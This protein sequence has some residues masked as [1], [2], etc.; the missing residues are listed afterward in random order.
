[1]T[2]LV[3]QLSSWIDCN[4][5]KKQNILRFGLTQHRTAYPS[6]KPLE[7]AW[8][9]NISQD[10]RSRVI[11]QAFRPGRPEGKI[12]PWQPNLM[13]NFAHAAVVLRNAGLE[14]WLGMY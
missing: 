14:K 4:H 6:H 13:M 12:V 9:E 3:N 8:I 2:I 10:G 1:M 11:P 7:L 5:L